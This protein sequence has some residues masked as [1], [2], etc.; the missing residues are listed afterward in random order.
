[1]VW[2][3]KVRLVEIDGENKWY[4]R[5][6]VELLNE[7]VEGSWDRHSQAQPYQYTA[8]SQI[9][10]IQENRGRTQLDRLCRSEPIRQEGVC[11]EVL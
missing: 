10:H 9:F 3:D 4:N 7:E 8:G 2:Y 5:L 1:M 11:S 6:L